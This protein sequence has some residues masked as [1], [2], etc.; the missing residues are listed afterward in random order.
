MFDWLIFGEDQNDT[1]E[2]AV[3]GEIQITW[4]RRNQYYVIQVL[5]GCIGHLD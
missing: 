2:E 4:L 3:F 5:L 1:V